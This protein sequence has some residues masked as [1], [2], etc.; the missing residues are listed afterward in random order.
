MRHANDGRIVDFGDDVVH[1]QP[2]V[3]V[4]RTAGDYFRDEYRRIVI[5]L[6]VVRATW[7]GEKKYG[8]DDNNLRENRFV[9][10]LTS[11]AETESGVASLQGDLV[12]DPFGFGV[13]VHLGGVQIEQRRH[14]FD[15]T[16]RR[17]G[18]GVGLLGGRRPVEVFHDVRGSDIGVALGTTTDRKNTRN[19]LHRTRGY[20]ISEKKKTI[21]HRTERTE[22]ERRADVRLFLEI[23]FAFIINFF[24]K[25]FY[26]IPS[27]PLRTY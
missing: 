1:A 25:Y 6:R 9:S 27:P 15:H 2:A 20:Y 18:G 7:T 24:P 3:P 5:G 26:A 21:T 17:G 12:D 10:K 16:I 23:G 19:K 13:A 22:D 4:G 11:Y 8:R 14:L